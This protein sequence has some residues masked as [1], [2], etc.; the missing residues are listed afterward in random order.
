[1]EQ[2]KDS[3]VS[4][5]LVDVIIPS[6]NR[7]ELVAEAIDSVRAQTFSGWR[8]AIV[9]DA[10]DDGSLEGV[11]QLTAGDAQS[12]VI[13]RTERG[14]PQA[15]R[16]TGFESSQAPYVATLDSDDLWA[17]TKLERQL[18][19]FRSEAASLSHLGAVLCWHQWIDTRPGGRLTEPVTKHRARGWASPLISANMST[20]LLR[21]EALD[22]A[23]GFLPTG[24]R[25][26]FTC[27]GEEFYIRLTQHCEFAVVHEKLVTCRHHLRGGKPLQYGGRR[28]AEEL[29]YVLQLHADRFDERS[30]ELAV[31]RA[32]V[33]ARY[34][35]AGLRRQGLAHL[36]SALRG[37]RPGYA[38][39]LLRRFGPFALKATLKKHRS[40]AWAAPDLGMRDSIPAD[41]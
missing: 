18:E 19:C 7:L 20:P 31:L 29:D 35:N 32:R 40:P 24:V 15:A 6:R 4:D 2:S 28:G 10:S 38:V 14:G 1:L 13:A 23:G 22:A 30:D 8:L 41:G 12:T 25:S 37:A 34:L 33:G 5:E 26:L 36:G 27:E 16:Q 9:D 17:P 11:R 3:T 21:R 39:G